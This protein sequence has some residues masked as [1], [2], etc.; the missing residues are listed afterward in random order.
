LEHAQAATGKAIGDDT[1][2]FCGIQLGT[3]F[4]SYFVAGKLI[5]NRQEVVPLFMIYC[6]LSSPESTDL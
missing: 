5:Y 6:P 3:A 1:F 2:Q 4:T